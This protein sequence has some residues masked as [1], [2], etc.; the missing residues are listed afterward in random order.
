[1][2]TTKPKPRKPAVA[3]ARKKQPPWL[4][5][6]VGGIVLVLAVAAIVSSGG[7]DDKTASAEGVEETRPV[8]VT[9]D[10]PANGSP[11]A[12]PIP[13]WARPIPEVKGQSFDGSPGR[14]HAT[15]A[16]R[17]CS[18]S[19]PTGAPTARRRFPSWPTT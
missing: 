5:I 16:G 7:S 1:M 10:G 12:A 8:T 9:G 17:S 3:A 15:T 18:S 4:W 19:S 2:A 14:D 6:G 13:P 11:T